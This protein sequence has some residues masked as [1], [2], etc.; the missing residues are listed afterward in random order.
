M[1]Y[2]YKKFIINENI[3]EG[4]FKYLNNKYKKK[5]DTILI[6]SIKNDDIYNVL[7]CIKKNID[8]NYQDERGLT[9]LMY[10]CMGGNLD[11]FNLIIKL[12]PST[13]IKDNNGFT[14]LTY[15]VIYDNVH[16]IKELIKR[17]VN[18]NTKSNDGGTPLIY[19]AWYNNK[20]SM[21]E[22]IE[23]DADWNIKDNYKRDFIDYS[24]IKHY[25]INKYDE[26]YKEYIFKKELD[27]Y[28]L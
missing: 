18:I 14:A 22:L 28:N 1:I 20:N 9:P 7:N 27:K 21:I 13:E 25:I 10:C 8:I 17:G 15:A 26:K 23:N 3:N 2:S 16:I 24:C 5:F 4:I 6:D 19:A 11:I 12:N